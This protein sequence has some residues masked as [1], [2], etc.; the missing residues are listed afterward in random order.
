MLNVTLL[1]SWLHVTQV[2]KRNVKFLKISA[3]GLMGNLLF[4]Y[5]RLRKEISEVEASAT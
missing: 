1:L 4:L 2:L 3:P 5:P